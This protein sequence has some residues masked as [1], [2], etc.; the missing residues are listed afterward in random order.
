MR[1]DIVMYEV[2]SIDDSLI[3]AVLADVDVLDPGTKSDVHAPT[4]KEEIQR[5]V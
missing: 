3:T 2:Q 4:L 5:L 1:L